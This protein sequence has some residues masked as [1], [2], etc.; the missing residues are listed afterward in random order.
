[1]QDGQHQQN[2]ECNNYKDQDNDVDCS[3][4]TLGCRKY[5]E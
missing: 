2:Q 4:D 3:F 1:L 5:I